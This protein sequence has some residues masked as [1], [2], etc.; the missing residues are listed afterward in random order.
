MSCWPL[1][2]MFLGFWTSRCPWAGRLFNTRDTNV[3]TGEGGSISRRS[4]WFQNIVRWVARLLWGGTI[5]FTRWM[6]WC[7]QSVHPLT[8]SICLHAY[9]LHFSLLYIGLICVWLYVPPG[10]LPPSTLADYQAQQFKI[11]LFL[12]IAFGLWKQNCMSD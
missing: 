1:P 8:K 9:E 12:Y 5:R 10:F 4:T 2:L 11:P 7:I 6:V 3:I